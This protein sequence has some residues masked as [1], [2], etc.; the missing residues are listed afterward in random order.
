MDTSVFYGDIT[1]FQRI[2]SPEIKEGVTGYM[3][4]N[5]GYISR[6]RVKEVRNLGFTY[7][8]LAKDGSYS[9]RSGYCPNLGQWY[10]LKDDDLTHSSWVAAVEESVSGSMAVEG[11][12]PSPKGKLIT[13]EFLKGNISSVE[14]IEQIKALYGKGES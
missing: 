9:G 14:A 1:K 6:V 4:C 3:L 2:D 11:L 12:S 8:I 13:R 10:L 5:G 7:S